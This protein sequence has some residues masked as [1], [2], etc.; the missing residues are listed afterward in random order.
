[1]NYICNIC[2]NLNN[3]YYDIYEWL[4]KDKIIHI[5]KIPV[6]KINNI[7]LKNIIKN[8]IKMD[9]NFLNLIKNKTEIIDFKKNINLCLF[10]DLKNHIIVQIAP[11]GNIIKK[12]DI[13]FTDKT[14]GFST[15][16]QLNY[17]QLEYKIIKN[18]PL[19]LSS[20]NE[21]ER[22]KYLIKNLNIL[23]KKKLSYLY[24]ECFNEKS[25]DEILIRQ[26]IKKEILL[27]NDVICTT[28]DNFLKL[29][30]APN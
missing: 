3:K 6:F 29:I 16:K 8:E 24:F 4:K 10:T 30:C 18:L 13:H 23:E 1:M 28:I 22:K 14:T 17:T 27:N 5:K 19:Q 15:L 20:R 21:E 2:A 11:N 12:S 7:D 25:D 9:S 26:K